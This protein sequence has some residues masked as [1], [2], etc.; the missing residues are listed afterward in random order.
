MRITEEELINRHVKKQILTVRFPYASQNIPVL[1]HFRN[2]EL[3]KDFYEFI[4]YLTGKR[5]K[6]YYREYP[7]YSELVKAVREAELYKPEKSNLQ[8]TKIEIKLI[9]PSKEELHDEEEEECQKL[10]ESKEEPYTYDI[11]DLNLSGK[12]E[13]ALQPNMPVKGASFDIQ[14]LNI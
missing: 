6:M 4:T 10:V 7:M 1:R 9:S 3:M 11:R 13:E 5:I 14:S 12:E 8:L 2:F